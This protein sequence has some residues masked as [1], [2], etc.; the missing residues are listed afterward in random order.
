MKNTQKS[1]WTTYRIK[2]PN[3]EKESENLPHACN[4]RKTQKAISDLR[5]F[6]GKCKTNQQQNPME[7]RLQEKKTREPLLLRIQTKKRT[8]G[9]QSHDWNSSK[10]K[11]TKIKRKNIWWHR[12]WPVRKC[13]CFDISLLLSFL[14][15]KSK[16]THFLKQRSPEGMG[17]WILWVFLLLVLRWQWQGQ[18]TE[19]QA[20]DWDGKFI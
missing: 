10:E 2:L 17:P 19:Q 11:K 3:P 1:H 20:C 7:N 16:G 14:K 6:P 12:D 9:S 15:S 8:H 4:T 5:I 18:E 13:F